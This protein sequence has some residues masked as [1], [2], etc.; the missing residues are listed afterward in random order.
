MKFVSEMEFYDADYFKNPDRNGIIREGICFFLNRIGVSIPIYP[1]QFLLGSGLEDPMVIYGYNPPTITE[2]LG[3]VTTRVGQGAYRKSIL[4]RWEYQCSVTN[5]NKLDI[6]IASHIVTW[7]QSNDAKR[8]D[9][10][11]GILFSQTYEALFDK[12]L[13]T[14]NQKGKIILSDKIEHSA[15]QKIGVTGNEQIR[16]LSPYNIH[17]LDRHNQI[18]AS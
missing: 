18:F 5:F 17:Y 3:M 16:E 6:L 13:I 7:E 10:Q 9:V 15:Y 2:R 1:N 4:Y 11:N 14:F 12:Y 8:L